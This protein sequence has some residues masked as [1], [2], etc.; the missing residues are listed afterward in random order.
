MLISQYRHRL[1]GYD[2]GYLIILAKRT[3][4]LLVARG[5]GECRSETH[6]KKQ[7]MCLSAA[8]ADVDAAMNTGFKYELSGSTYW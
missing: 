6:S 2:A 4:A 5:F 8:K 1:A 7:G 3:L